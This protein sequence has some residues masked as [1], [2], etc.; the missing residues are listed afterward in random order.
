MT[1][2]K[3]IQLDNN[4]ASLRNDR[5]VLTVQTKG[6]LTRLDIIQSYRVA[7]FV[8]LARD[9]SPVCWPLAPDF[10]D[11]QL[12]FSTGYVYPAK[13]RNVQRNARVAVLYSDPTASRR[14]DDDPLVLIQ[15]LAKADDMDLQRNTERYVDQ[16][17]RKGPLMFR[18]ALRFHTL[19]QAFV[20]YLTRIWIEVQPQREFVWERGQMPPDPLCN[21]IRPSSFPPK[22]G[23][24]LPQEIFKWLLN[25][26]RLPVLAYLDQ[27]GWPAITRV[28]ANVKHDH[29]TFESK[30]QAQPGAPACLT[31]HR[32][33]GNYLAN[34]A[35]LLRGHFDET[36][37]FIPE[38]VVGFQGTG[39]DRGIGSIK[40]MRVLLG[41]RKQLSQ[42][43]EKESRPL[44]IARPTPGLGLKNN[45]RMVKS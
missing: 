26:Q 20:G 2:L 16:L 13:A 45:H 30:I 23:I 7:E 11:G 29:I 22:P 24:E 39:D 44:P 36:N 8:T 1:H 32:L 4:P 35:F 15:G 40:A 9:G 18:A 25:Y 38:K 5:E 6:N 19:R 12:V 27:A 41:F 31:Y 43:L 17:L 28:Q 3:T 14:T 37:R 33:V 42:Q 21:A 34:D 10:E